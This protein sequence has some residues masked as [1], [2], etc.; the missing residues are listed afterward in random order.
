MGTTVAYAFLL[1]CQYY[2]HNKNINKDQD[3]KGLFHKIEF[4]VK[5]TK[6]LTHTG[7]NY[8][9]VFSSGLLFRMVVIK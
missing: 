2:S 9:A 7:R 4:R 6:L 8:Y 1:R 5:G 3:E